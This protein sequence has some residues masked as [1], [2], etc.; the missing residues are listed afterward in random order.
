MTNLNPN[1]SILLPAQVDLW[2]KLGQTPNHFVLYGG[3]GLALRL[4]HR[5]SI[6]FD[7]FS[8]EE[9]EPNRLFN[10]IPYLLDQEI[11]STDKNTLDALVTTSQGVV[12]CSYFGVPRLNQAFTPDVA[13]D[14]GIALASLHDIFATKCATIAHRVE[15]KDYLDIHA[16]ITIAKLPLVE[17]LAAAKTVYGN[18]FNPNVALKAIQH[19]EGDIGQQLSIGQKSDL[20]KAVKELGYDLSQLA[21]IGEGQRIGFGLSL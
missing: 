11:L 6:D 13:I 9:F 17:G 1:L 16:L 5:E 20:V 15:V 14:N 4:G 18:Q 2:S 21:G 7:F 8:H 19:F 3:T 12:K 10:K